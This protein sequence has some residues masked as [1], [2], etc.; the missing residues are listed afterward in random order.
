MIGESSNI[1]TLVNSERISRE[2]QIRPGGG[3]E[4]EDSKQQSYADVASFSPQA[5]ALARNVAP[6]GASAEQ[7]QTQSQGRQQ[8]ADSGL[9]ARLLDIRI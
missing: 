6:T 5:L 8:G 4:E 3:Q 9:S 2:N 7:E 1:S